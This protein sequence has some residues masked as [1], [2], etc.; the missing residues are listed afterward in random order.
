MVFSLLSKFWFKNERSWE[1]TTSQGNYRVASSCNKLS[2]YPLGKFQEILLELG[3]LSKLLIHLMNWYPKMYFSN[4]DPFFFFKC[5]DFLLSKLD[6]IRLK[7]EEGEHFKIPLQWNLPR[8][9]SQKPLCKII[10]LFLTS[11]PKQTFHRSGNKYMMLDFIFP[12][13]N[14]N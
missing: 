14:Y 5:L 9:K 10:L 8:W 3:L 13:T 7:K 1:A 6:Y 11:T 12:K 4:L 2:K